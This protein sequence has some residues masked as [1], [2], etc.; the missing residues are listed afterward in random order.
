MGIRYIVLKPELFL[1]DFEY[2]MG[3]W[4]IKCVFSGTFILHKDDKSHFEIVHKN[5]VQI[6]GNQIKSH[7]YALSQEDRNYS[8]FF[9]Q[10]V[11]LKI[12]RVPKL[13]IL[14]HRLPLLFISLTRVNNAR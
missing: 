2:F 5:S 10:R 13:C 4:G 9:K 14:L 12:Q 7:F 1:F 8:R 11:K 6:L 3:F